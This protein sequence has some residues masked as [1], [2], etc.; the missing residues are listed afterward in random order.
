M[1]HRVADVRPKLQY[2]FHRQEATPARQRLQGDTGGKHN[3]AMLAKR[4]THRCV[5]PE[6]APSHRRD[7]PTPKGDTAPRPVTTTRRM[8]RAPN[9]SVHVRVC[10]DGVRRHA[11]AAHCGVQLGAS[12]RHARAAAMTGIVLPSVRCQRCARLRGLQ[13][14]ARTCKSIDRYPQARSSDRATHAP[15]ANRLAALP[16]SLLA[17][18]PRVRAD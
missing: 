18:W 17:A 12:M 6:H 13:R 2:R 4:R 3:F 8:Q 10:G 1:S 9:S 7:T 15:R 16:L 14:G 5:P 11:L